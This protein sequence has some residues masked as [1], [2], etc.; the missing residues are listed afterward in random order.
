MISPDLPEKG[1]H[2]E[3]LLTEH[4]EK[5]FIFNN[6]WEEVSFKKESQIIFSNRN[7][8]LKDEGRIWINEIEG[9]IFKQ[10]KEWE[11]VNCGD[12]EIFEHP[13]KP[14]RL[15]DENDTSGN[16]VITE[17]SLWV[18]YKHNKVYVNVDPSHK[19]SIWKKI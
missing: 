6:G 12:E 4:D 7:P 10:L 16:G 5:C 11:Q 3:V 18:D 15:D 9:L 8:S 2:G 17:G 14:T 13:F 19:L 1:S